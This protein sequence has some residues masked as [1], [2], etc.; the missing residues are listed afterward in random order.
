VRNKD[1]DYLI[2][3]ELQAS[4]ASYTGLK[5]F[6]IQDCGIQESMGAVCD[7]T[8][9]H[10]GSSD[11]HLI[12]LRRFMLRALRDLQAGTDPCTA[13]ADYRL[14]VFNF[15]L[16]QGQSVENEVR[17]RLRPESIA[18]SCRAANATRQTAAWSPRA[19]PTSWRESVSQVPVQAFRPAAGVGKRLL[20][21]R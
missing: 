2:D 19:R 21:P 20:R 10:L 11:V 16:P 4:G 15:T 14:R 13:G 17:G 6:G 1:N 9:E 8:R 7:R 3:R 5:G 12:Q 18:G